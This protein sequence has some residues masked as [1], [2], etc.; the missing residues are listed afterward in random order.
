M[1]QTWVI[2]LVAIA[3][4]H[5]VATVALYYWLGRRTVEDDPGSGGGSEA[6]A[7]AGPEENAKAGGDGDVSAGAERETASDQ[8]DE[9]VCSNCGTPNAAGYRYCRQC[10][11]PLR[12][13][14]SRSG[15][16]SGPNSPWIR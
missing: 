12:P 13:A 6:E 2:A 14:R 5:F 11:S 15:N 16:D 10:V 7:R 8:R 3:I 1:A 4:A 9:V